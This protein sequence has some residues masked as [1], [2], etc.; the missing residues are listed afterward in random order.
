MS[1][2]IREHHLA[3]VNPRL[4]GPAAMRVIDA[5]QAHRPVD[6]ATGIAVCFLLLCRKLK[7]H[8]GNVLEIATRLLSTDS[9]LYPEL[10]A[11]DLYITNEI[12]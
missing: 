8:P 7:L 2:P 12:N 6:Q 1:H 3:N 10:R 4:V 11:A 9:R 5:I